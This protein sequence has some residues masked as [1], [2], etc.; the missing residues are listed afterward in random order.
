MTSSDFKQTSL[1]VVLPVALTQLY[2]KSLDLWPG[3][4]SGEFRY[5]CVF[6]DD[7]HKIS[8]LRPDVTISIRESQTRF[9]PLSEG[10]MKV[11]RVIVVSPDLIKNTTVK[12][13]KD[14]E[15]FPFATLTRA[16]C[17]YF[18]VTTPAGETMVIEPR[19][20]F[21]SNDLFAAHEAAK[22]GIAFAVLPKF[23]VE[24]DLY[25]GRL[26]SLL[27]A[28]LTQ[29]YIVQSEISSNCQNLVK[30]QKLSSSLLEKMNTIPGISC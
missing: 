28:W 10:Q 23:M 2:F 5:E 6:E 21:G 18:Y 30:A 20:S 17:R 7:P 26:I 19:R 16:N 14:L 25:S 4:C 9:K 24:D 13:P 27:P 22:H 3:D 29:P 12:T 11:R 8:R 1:R 15:L